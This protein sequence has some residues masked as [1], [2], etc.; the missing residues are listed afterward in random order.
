M[1]ATRTERLTYTCLF[2]S[3]IFFE[4]PLLHA[5]DLLRALATRTRFYTA[6][7]KTA[8]DSVQSYDHTFSASECADCYK[9]RAFFVALCS[10]QR[11]GSMI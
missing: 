8:I 1:V 3:Y 2:I 9:M 4:A 11:S 7:R 5:S 10:Q 6:W